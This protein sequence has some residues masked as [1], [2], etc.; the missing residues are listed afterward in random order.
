MESGISTSLI[1]PPYI[2]FVLNVIGTDYL[3]LARMVFQPRH[4]KVKLAK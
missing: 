1:L 3:C 2:C 4:L